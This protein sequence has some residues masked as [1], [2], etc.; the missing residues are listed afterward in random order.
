MIRL[1][2]LYINLWI[3]PLFG[4]AFFTGSL[5]ALCI[6]YTA[7]LLHE[8]AHWVAARRLDIPTGGIALMPFGAQLRL[9][10]IL[11]SDPADEV[12]L[13]AAGPLMN[14]V[15]AAGTLFVRLMTGQTA[16]CHGLD[17][18]LAANASVF[19]LN[20]LPILPLDGGRILRAVLTHTSGF[21]KASRICAW[22]TPV[23][24]LLVG[25]FGIWVLFETRFNVSVMVFV[26]F[27]LFNLSFEK[28]SA[29]LTIMRQVACAKEK[30]YRRRIMPARELAVAADVPAGKLISSFSYNSFYFV[31]VISSGAEQGR[32]AQTEIAG[33]RAAPKDS[34]LQTD[35]CNQLRLHKT[36]VYGAQKKERCNLQRNSN[37]NQQYIQNKPQNRYRLNSTAVFQYQRL[38]EIQ[39]IDGARRL[40]AHTPVGQLIAADK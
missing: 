7:V 5:T 16:F 12:V 8:L 1:G 23:F 24:T 3:I 6:S 40:G 30:L 13:C 14:L 15:L 35:S 20:V 38:S 29:Q 31:S 26:T 18:F 22:I 9:R 32:C 27:L 4:M 34:W 33:K 10:D 28:K 2:K 37:R 19:L 21:L 25:L 36:R 17:L 11:I 39:I